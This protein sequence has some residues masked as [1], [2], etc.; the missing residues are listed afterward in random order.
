MEIEI[1]TTKKKLTRSIVNQ[2]FRASNK[3]IMCGEPVGFIVNV[4]KNTPKAILIQHGGNYYI[5][6]SNYE[7]ASQRVYRYSGKRIRERT[8]DTP[9]QCNLWWDRYQKVLKLASNQIYI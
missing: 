5:M 2:M 8:F 7:K 4:V 3:I 1:I 6:S 9:E